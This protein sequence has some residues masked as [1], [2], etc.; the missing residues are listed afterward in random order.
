MPHS[1]SMTENK[2]FV[3]KEQYVTSRSFY[4]QQ[5]RYLLW[6]LYWNYKMN[7]CL[8]LYRNYKVNICLLL[9]WKLQSEY[10]I[11]AIILKIL[12]WISYCCSYIEIIKW[13]FVCSYIEIIKWIFVCSYIENYKV[14]ICLLLYW[15]LQS[16]YLFVALIL[17]L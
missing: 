16:E 11:V 13:I 5:N 15:K 3:M 17:K 8:F 10:L 2:P 6:P 14:N 9:Y 12:K 7:I 4:N 1:Q